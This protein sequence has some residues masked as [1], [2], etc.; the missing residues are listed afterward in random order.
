MEDLIDYCR[1]MSI[2]EILAHPDVNERVELYRE[3]SE[4]FKQ[5]LKDKSVVEGN[6]II[7]DLRGVKTIFAG[8]RFVVYSLFPEQNISVWV[9]D[10]KNKENCSIAVGY[11]VLNRTASVDIGSILL[12]YGGGGHKQVGT[13]QVSYEDCDR[14]I[15]ELTEKFK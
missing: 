3:Q 14:V 2:G 15:K 10:G 11:S 6:A 12:S 5:M 8:N 1:T 7:T 4:L 13:C 9:V